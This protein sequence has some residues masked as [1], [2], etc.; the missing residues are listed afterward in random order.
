MPGGMESS[1][2][3]PTQRQ[4]AATARSLRRREDELER[5]LEDVREE[6]DEAIRQ[7]SRDRV[8]MRA[9]ARAFGLSHQRVHQIVQGG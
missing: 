2:A 9:I 8:P 6:R 4:L 7:A 3:R 5:Q 1:G